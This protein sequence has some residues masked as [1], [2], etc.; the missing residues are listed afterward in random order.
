VRHTLNGQGQATDS[1][2]SRPAEFASDDAALIADGG[3]AAE[4]EA[5][6]NDLAA[7]LA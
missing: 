2:Y 5:R 6:G 4:L 7:A 3:L 1:S